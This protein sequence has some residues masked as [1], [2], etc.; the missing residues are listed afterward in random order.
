MKGK[1]EETRK[2]PLSQ[3]SSAPFKCHVSVVHDSYVFLANEIPMF[4]LP[5][6]SNEIS[7]RKKSMCL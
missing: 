2:E 7:E 1:I 3:S 5:P 4:I 6:H